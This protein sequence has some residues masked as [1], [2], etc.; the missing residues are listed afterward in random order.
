[1]QMLAVDLL[2]YLPTISSSML[3][4]ALSLCSSQVLDHR[5]SCRIVRVLCGRAEERPEERKAVFKWL[6]DLLS[7]SSLCHKSSA[8]TK[9]AETAA[10]ALAKI[11]G[12]ISSRPSHALDRMAFNA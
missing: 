9:L 2:H 12:K 7:Q 4:A 1:M 5:I 8:D 3:A 6:T 11:V 10:A